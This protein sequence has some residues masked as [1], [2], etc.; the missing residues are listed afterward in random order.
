MFSFNDLSVEPIINACGTVTRLGGSPLRPEALDAYQQASLLAVP[1]EE[2]QTAVSKQLAHWTGAEAGIITSGA[3]AALT[4][5]AAAILAGN[6][7]ARM[8]C[9]P[10]TESMPNEFIIS[11]DQRSGYDHAVR[12]SG[13]SLHEVGLNE[14]VSGAGVRRTETWE[15][16]SAISDKTAGILYVYTDDSA[17]NLDE[18]VALGK[19]HGIPI[20]I[21][22][23]GELPPPSNLKKLIKSGANL[24]AFSGG[25]AIG[26]PQATGLLLGQKQLVGSALLQMLDM[27]DHP[28]LWNPIL[29]DKSELQ[30]MPR[31]GIGRGFKVSKESIMALMAAINCFLNEDNSQRMA[32]LAGILSDIQT[33]LEE[34]GISSQLVWSDRETVPKLQ[35]PTRAAFEVCQNLRSHSP[36]VFVGHGLL[37]QGILT[38]NAIAL[39]EHQVNSLSQALI[40]CVQSE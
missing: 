24:V 13:A 26:G 10:H 6:D 3:A 34:A 15:Y 17:P 40:N 31:H 28:Q 5:G 18:V 14:V 16:E 2:L 27:D 11:R 9:L 23:A 39:R 37:D 22:A 19:Q 36:R 20:L 29:S 12:A 4:L 7:P 1:L 32:I 21:D 35:I 8:E 25:K 38:I 30:G 33:T